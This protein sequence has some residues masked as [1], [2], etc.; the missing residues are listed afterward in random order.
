[1]SEPGSMQ[2]QR[3]KGQAALQEILR[4]MGIE[5]AKVESFEQPDNESGQE[6]GQELDEQPR[7]AKP[8]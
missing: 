3:E 1:M 7:H 8:Q 2:E 4:L 5:A 6:P